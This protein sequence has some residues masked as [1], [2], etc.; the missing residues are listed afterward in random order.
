MSVDQ[1]LWG[2]FLCQPVAVFVGRRGSV[3]VD[4]LVGVGWLFMMECRI[5]IKKGK[6]RKSVS[7]S[8]EQ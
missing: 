2:W 6:I 3:A 7:L 4:L 1:S 8:D 5:V